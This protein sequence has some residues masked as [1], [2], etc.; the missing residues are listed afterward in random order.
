MVTMAKG[1]YYRWRRIRIRIMPKEDL[2]LLCWWLLW[3][4]YLIQSLPWIIGC[5][6]HR[7]FVGSSVCGWL[8]IPGMCIGMIVIC[9][10]STQ[11]KKRMDEKDEDR[12]NLRIAA[13][14]RKGHKAWQVRIMTRMLKSVRDERIVNLRAWGGEIRW[15]CCCWGC[16]R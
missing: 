3:I 14:R 6:H 9:H 7:C 4:R 16:R 8:R 10:R 13:G 11:S 15:R 12:W 5:G 2:L 1:K